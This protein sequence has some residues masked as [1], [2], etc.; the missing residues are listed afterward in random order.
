MVLNL[1]LEN[2]DEE[3]AKLESELKRLD[4]EDGGNSMLPSPEKKDSTLM[5][6]REL[7]ISPDS[8]KFGNLNNDDLKYVRHILHVANFFESQNLKPYAAYMRTKAENILSTSMSHKGWF[9]NLIVTQI[10][11]ETKVSGTPI[12]KQGWF[13]KKPEGGQNEQV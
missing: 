1:A 2:I 10:K 8:R 12:Q 11:K 5:L 6:F 7:I 4:S 9:G 3:L 13:S